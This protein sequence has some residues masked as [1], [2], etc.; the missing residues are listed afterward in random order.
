MKLPFNV[1]FTQAQEFFADKV[2]L[3]REEFD[4]LTKWAKL[5]GATIA[6]VT[7][8]DVITDVFAA[9][10]KAQS[11]GLPF[12]GFVAEFPDIMER[13]GW[14]GLT[15]WHAETVFRTNNQMAYG[16]GRIE[17]QRAVKDWFPFWA[18]HAL[19]DS[20][21][22][23]EHLAL[24]G[25]VLPTGDQFWADHY[26]PWDYNCR[27]YVEVLTAEEADEIGI[28][29]VSLFHPDDG[30]DF[31]GPGVSFDYTPDLSRYDLG[32]QQAVEREIAV[33]MAED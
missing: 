13:H 11:E 27:C 26:P 15:P 16:V 18:Y 12:S 6:A 7:K 22:R 32:I 5:R 2:S 19:H 8:A 33:A 10:R 30:G 29:P 23:I 31:A 9:M 3:V 14:G 20:R 24:D 28:D 1:P 4:R 25:T 21:V 17:Q